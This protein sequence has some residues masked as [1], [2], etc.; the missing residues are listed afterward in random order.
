MNYDLN[1]YS[2][3]VI[4]GIGNACNEHGLP[5]PTVITESGRA[6][7][8]YHVALVSNAFGVERHEFSE[9]LPP[10][11]DAPYVLESMWK[12]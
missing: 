10:A 4:C 7:T 2:N 12:T 11:E 3:S 8:A 5:H 6:M 9:P 1:E